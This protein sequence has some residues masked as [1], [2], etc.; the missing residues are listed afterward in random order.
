M[1][2]HLFSEERP[3]RLLPI[4]PTVLEELSRSYGI[5]RV[6]IAEGEYPGIEGH[7]SAMD[8]AGWILMTRAE[9]PENV[10]YL[11]AQVMAEDHQSFDAQYARY[12]VAQS[13]LHYPIV[14]ADLGR[15]SPLPLHP[16]ATRF[17][18]EA[19]LL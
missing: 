11:I 3:M 1:H 9:L 10:A 14:P 19:G 7:G 12:P 2:W 8:W 15:T 6:D 18:R 4:D 13:P 5:R 16:G 17:Y